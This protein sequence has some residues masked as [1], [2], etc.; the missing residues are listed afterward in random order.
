M[1]A[2]GKLTMMRGDKFLVS[3]C[4]SVLFQEV[5]VSN[6]EVLEIWLNILVFEE[7]EP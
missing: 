1:R 7:R 4:T 3:P 6:F 5:P 2:H